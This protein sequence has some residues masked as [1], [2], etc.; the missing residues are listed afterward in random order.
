MKI[1]QIEA[2]RSLGDAV[3]NN[4]LLRAGGVKRIH[5]GWYSVRYNGVSLDCST[6]KS[7]KRNFLGKLLLSKP[8]NP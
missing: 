4:E 6:V 1:E 3:N 7:A 2:N 5:A 8:A